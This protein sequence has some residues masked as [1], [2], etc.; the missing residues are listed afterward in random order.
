ME[1]LWNIW[2]S[3]NV[4]LKKNLRVNHN[5]ILEKRIN[6]ENFLTFGFI[7]AAVKFQGHT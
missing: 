3:S 6:L 5:P 1:Y 2:R 7:Q 4:Y